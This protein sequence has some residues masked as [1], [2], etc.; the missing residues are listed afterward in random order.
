MALFTHIIYF[1]AICEPALATWRGRANAVQYWNINIS[2]SP[3][4]D[5]DDR[6][7]SDVACWTQ[8]TE[9]EAPGKFGDRWEYQDW[10]FPYIGA[11]DSI[12]NS[13]S[14]DCGRCFTVTY[15][16]GRETRTAT[17]LAID[18][19]AKSDW[20]IEANWDFIKWITNGEV[21]KG[22]TFNAAVQATH[23]SNCGL[24]PRFFEDTWHAGL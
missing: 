17:L 12:I 19:L 13:T 2:H 9:V 16:E 5:E 14:I 18:K 10:V 22:E 7:A 11:M 8:P 1:L 20:G 6:P 15:Y 21:K 23:P 4:L 3:L 24:G